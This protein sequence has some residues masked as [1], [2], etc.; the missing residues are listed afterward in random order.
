MNPTKPLLLLLVLT[1][2]FSLAGTEG[3]AQAVDAPKSERELAD[4]YTKYFK[5]KNIG[6]ILELYDLNGVKPEFIDRLKAA[7]SY[8]FGKEIKKISFEPAREAGEPG[9]N[10]DYSYLQN[11]ESG[12]PVARMIPTVAPTA[13]MKVVFP[14]SAWREKID[15][16][17]ESA[18]I[19]HET[20]VLSWYTMVGKKGDRY[21]LV[22]F[23]AQELG[24]AAPA[25]QQELADLYAAYFAEKNVDKILSLY[26]FTG[27]EPG[28]VEQTR[29]ITQKY[30]GRKIENISFIPPKP[31]DYSYESYDHK[32][33]MLP[34]VTPVKQM[35]VKFFIETWSANEP[36]GMSPHWTLV[37]KKGEG[38]YLVSFKRQELK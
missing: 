13:Q 6:K 38:Y 32:A 37:G 24:A 3:R 9:F 19:P 28:V 15:G 22:A 10:P 12:K 25:S 11:D 8:H 18:G 4:L 2:S 7:H 14:A 29:G 21:C 5:E 27:V 23:K 20:G 17:T 34:T 35:L 30:F 16:A 33:R 1:A 31:D 36:V 26:D